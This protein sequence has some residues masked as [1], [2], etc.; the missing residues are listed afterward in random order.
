MPTLTVTT[1]L[2]YGDSTSDNAVPCKV[3]LSY[4]LDYTEKTERRIV[5]DT[6]GSETMSVDIGENGPKFIL[7][8]IESGDAVVSIESSTSGN[9]SP[10]IEF[11]EETDKGWL[12][13]VGPESNT[14]DTVNVSTTDGATI[15]VLAI[16]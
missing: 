16:A 3:P 15:V 4:S 5:L 1:T 12:T 14:I 8:R 6:G 11:N 10:E 13:L 2:T 7:A 9:V